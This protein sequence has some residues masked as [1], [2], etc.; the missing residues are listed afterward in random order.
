MTGLVFFIFDAIANFLALINLIFR[1]LGAS[2]GLSSVASAGLS[3]VASAGLS[4]SFVSSC[5]I[6]FSTSATKAS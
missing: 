2:A 3:S 4:P 6:A 5:L 1:A